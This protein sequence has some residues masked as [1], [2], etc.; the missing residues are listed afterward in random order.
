MGAGVERHFGPADGGVKKTS[1]GTLRIGVTPYF[2]ALPLIDGLEAFEDVE[3]FREPPSEL[4]DLLDSARI[5]AALLPAAD[6]LAGRDRWQMAA[7]YG[8]VAAGPVWT[9]KIFSDVPLRK[10]AQLHVDAESHSSAALAKVIF[11]EWEGQEVQ[12]IP[13]AFRAGAVDT[14]RNWLLIGDKAFAGIDRAYVYDLGELWFERTGLPFIFALWAAAGTAPIERI[15][16]RLCETADRNLARVDHLAS[17]YGPEH[18]FDSSVAREYLGR[19]I[20]YRI[21]AR[22]LKGL[23]RFGKLLAKHAGQRVPS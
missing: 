4:A 6:Y 19:V 16:K 15:G 11:R 10:I 22:E 2:N 7:P 1:V 18:G 8:I 3:V 17:L 23:E 5:D 9:V 12:F 13:Q 20:H 21:G 14:D